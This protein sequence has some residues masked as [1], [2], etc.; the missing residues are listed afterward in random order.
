MEIHV[1]GPFCKVGLHQN[2][3]PHHKPLEIQVIAI[4]KRDSPE[5]PASWLAGRT[6]PNLNCVWQVS[7]QGRVPTYHLEPVGQTRI[8]KN[9]EG[10]LMMSSRCNLL[11]TPAGCARLRPF[12]ALLLACKIAA[13]CGSSW[14]QQA[15]KTRA[16]IGCGWRA[17]R[18]RDWR[19]PRRGPR[20]CSPPSPAG[21][22]CL[23]PPATRPRFCAEQCVL[24]TRRT[25]SPC[26]R[27]VATMVR[28][29][30]VFP[31]PGRPVSSK[32]LP[33]RQ[34]PTGSST[35]FHLRCLGR[36]ASMRGA[37]LLPSNGF[38][39]STR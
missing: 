6:G 27:S 5:H 18:G 24:D 17:E 34:W 9:R 14:A 28:A 19:R 32:E 15:F 22:S 35:P 38:V 3:W 7:R 1:Q 12:C 29:R 31:V 23:C 13:A 25:A 2:A 11:A 8:S 36:S 10:F 39:S 16:V 26:S 37:L 20:S 30:C 21:R 33:A 4:G